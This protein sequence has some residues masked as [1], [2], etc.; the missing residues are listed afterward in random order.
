MATNTKTVTEGPLTL[1]IKPGIRV[2]TL[3]LT[4]MSANTLV[5]TGRSLGVVVYGPVTRDLNTRKVVDGYDYAFAPFTTQPSEVFFDIPPFTDLELTITLTASS[6]NVKCGCVVVG[7]YTYLGD[8]KCGATND[9][10]NF[11]TFDR[12]LWGGV[13]LVPRP[14]VPKTTQTLHLPSAHVNKVMAAR[15]Q[16]NGV[17]GLYTGLDD[18][19]SDFFDMLARVGVYKT[20]RIEATSQGIATIQLDVEEI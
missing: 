11:S 17:P 9:P 2:N 18:G 3:G 1:V 13:T 16:L 12:D 7:T 8:V 6:G 10:L 5:V 20:F 15:A 19:D 14:S 4:G